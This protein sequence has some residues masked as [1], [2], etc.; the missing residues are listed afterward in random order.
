MNIYS[1]F[2]PTYTSPSPTEGPIYLDYN[3]TTPIDPQVASAMLPY[4]CKHWGNPSSSHV[5]GQAAKKGVD[6][7]RQ[8]VAKALNASKPETILFTSGGTESANHAIKGAVERKRLALLANSTNTSS[9]I[10]LG[11]TNYS[12]GA[13][14]ASATVNKLPHVITCI[15]EHPCVLEVCKYLQTQGKCDLTILPVDSI[16]RID[17][18]SLTQAITKETALVTIMHAN[19][20]SGVIQDIAGIA[21]AARTTS[22]NLGSQ[23]CGGILIHTDASQSMGKVNIDVQT[24]DVDLLT[25]AGHKVYA[26]KGV[27]CLYIRDTLK[28]LPIFMHG[29]GHENGRRAG[30]ESVLLMAGFGEGCEMATTATEKD[31]HVLHD[32]ASLL[33]NELERLC[34]KNPIDGSSRLRINGPSLNAGDEWRLPNTVNVGFGGAVTSGL[35][36][37]KTEG[38]LAFSAA[39]A[40][41]KTDGNKAFISSVIRA[42]NTPREYALG[43]VRLSVGRYTTDKEIKTAARLLSTVAND[44]WR[45]ETNNEQK[46]KEQVTAKK[47]MT[48]VASRKSRRKLAMP[49]QESGRVSTNEVPSIPE[50]KSMTTTSTSS[51]STPVGNLLSVASSIILSLPGTKPVFWDDTYLFQGNAAC[52]ESGTEENVKDGSMMTTLIL[53]ATLFHPQGGG[54][55]TDTGEIISRDGNTFIVNMVRQRPDNTIV[56]YGTYENNAEPF[57]TGEELRLQVNGENRLK[58]SRSH[59][60]GHLLDIAM[61]RTGRIMKGLKGYHF[62]KGA[63]VEFEGKVEPKDRPPLVAMLQKHCDALVAENMPTTYIYATSKEEL[64][65]ACLEGAAEG[66]IAM[67]RLDVAPVR[68]V[69]IGGGGIPCGGT[70]VRNTSEVGKITVTKCKVKKGVTRISYNTK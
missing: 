4:L 6:H 68:V 26:P 38:Q 64:E 24:L 31:S 62:L 23:N 33:F 17:L 58:A 54:Q 56:H 5:Y 48:P 7:A 27:G 14:T 47:L 70:H 22:N 34:D 53:N 49:R 11:H 67:G 16:G 57:S 19:N 63:Y 10:P 46:K 25:L 32:R 40:C 39:S 9:T 1:G 29:A 43:S 66:A 30:T 21:N 3:A 13:T 55:P 52:V 20:E 28:D 18:A 15:T 69:N 12:Y 50:S 2:E 45:N 36:Q 37:E 65:K 41:H 59:T 8:Q 44:V 42:M 61:M 51:S 35:L 60:A